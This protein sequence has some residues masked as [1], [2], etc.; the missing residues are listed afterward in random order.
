MVIRAYGTF[1]LDAGFPGWDGSEH[2]AR[3][4]QSELA[5]QV[6]LSDALRMPLRTIAGFSAADTD[7][8]RV[9]AAAVLLDVQTLEPL[10][11][12]VCKFPAP[13]PY[14]RELLGF[15]ALP[16]MLETLSALP[17]EPDLAMVEGHGIAHPRR[18]G[19]ATHFGL[20]SGLPTIGVARGRLAGAFV[21][22]GPLEGE[23]SRLRD[24]DQQ[25]GWAVR[26]RSESPPI[27]VSP[28]HRVSLAA[29]LEYSL[30]MQC[31][32]RL[33]E[34]VHLARRLATQPDEWARPRRRGM[35]DTHS[36]RLV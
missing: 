28:G 7:D 9:R 25:I 35:R 33:P 36:S 19:L 32:H 26:T 4:L 34:P 30:Q 3:L 16:A 20:A 24:G 14:V 12:E 6:Q 27:F 23:A 21:E 22:P 18:C 1:R 29:S 13:L 2:G 17:R 10:H 8:G 31:G 15:R 5:S 11:A